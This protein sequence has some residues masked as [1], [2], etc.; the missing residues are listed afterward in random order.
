MKYV[1]N[2]GCIGC[3]LCKGTCPEVFH[4]TDEG[5]A[6]AIETEVPKKRWQALRKQRTDV[7]SAQL[8]KHKEA[9]NEKACK[10]K[11]Q[12]GRLY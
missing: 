12:L 6:A 5:A 1:V 9:V 3:G 2:D 10:R 8:K 11:C 4:M 7:L